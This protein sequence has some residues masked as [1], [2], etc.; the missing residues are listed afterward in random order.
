MSSKVH[1]RDHSPHHHHRHKHHKKHK[2][3][4]SPS[5]R[6]HSRSP[7]PVRDERESHHRPRKHK[8]RHHDEEKYE[9]HRE[10]STSPR[11]KERRPV[12]R[13]TRTDNG[14]RKRRVN[15]FSDGDNEHFPVTIKQERDVNDERRRR[16][17]K[18]KPT[19]PFQTS[20]N[21]EYGNPGTS[22]EV[23]DINDTNQ[24]KKGPDF[25]LSGKLA[26]ETNTF[27]GVVI[28]YNEPPE[29]RKPKKKWRLYV[30]KGQEQLPVLHIHRQSAYLFGRDRVV[31]DIPIDHPS[32]SKQHAALQFRLVS[33]ERVDGSM[34]RRVKP[35]VIDLNSSNGT[36]VNNNK[37]EPQRYVELFEKDVV[38]FGYSSREYVLLHEK[39]SV[40]D[41][42][43][44]ET[45]T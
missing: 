7:S 36:V 42:D 25:K 5:R 6:S 29:A 19:N 12:S 17:H 37:I 22:A 31:A 39:S 9:W 44:E 33:Y 34:G 26:E 10:H 3:R 23:N 24:P 14:D 15:R 41:T 32:C 45:K 43:D 38:K 21:Y 8:I 40:V 1:H 20:E 27:R 35:F 30:F 16:D 28:K 4:S 18:R 11:R 13:D 2:K